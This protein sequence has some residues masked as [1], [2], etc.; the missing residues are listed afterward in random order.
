MTGSTA[1]YIDAY[2][3]ERVIEKFGRILYGCDILDIDILHSLISSFPEKSNVREFDDMRTAFHEYQASYNV[4]CDTIKDFHLMFASKKNFSVERLYHLV[5]HFEEHTKPTIENIE[6]SIVALVHSV[7]H[8][9]HFSWGLIRHIFIEKGKRT[10][11]RLNSEIQKLKEIVQ[12]LQYSDFFAQ[13]VEDSENRKRIEQ[14]RTKQSEHLQRAKQSE[15]SRAASDARRA[16]EE[17]LQKKEEARQKRVDDEAEWRR[18]HTERFEQYPPDIFLPAFTK[19]LKHLKNAKVQN[20]NKQVLAEAFAQFQEV[21]VAHNIVPVGDAHLVPE[22]E[23]RR[24]A[25]QAVL[26]SF[27]QEEKYWNSL[28]E[29]GH[30]TEDQFSREIET[31]DERRSIEVGRMTGSKG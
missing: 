1:P 23:L 6:K 24:K 7:S 14:D 31:L 25:Q 9:S 11:Q 22:F 20:A 16:R 15:E 5:F 30:I 28:Y 18:K 4:L 3:L 10:M 26:F 13:V 8:S 12:R 19:Q 17:R 29:A 21:L 27:V 2:K